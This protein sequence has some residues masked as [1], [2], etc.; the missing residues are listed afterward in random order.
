MNTG[1]H[2]GHAEPATLAVPASTGE[3]Q[4]VI[5]AGVLDEAHVYVREA[6]GDA[7][8]VL[9]VA[10]ETVAALGY[11]SRVE[12]A[13]SRAFAQV[14]TAV[15]PAGESSKS[16]AQAVQ[17]Y[18]ECVRAGLDR[19][20]LVVALGGGVVGDLA[21]FVAATY[22]R[23]VRFVQMPTTL[24][25]H[26]SSIGGKVG[27]NLPEG[28][29]LVGAFHAPRLV[30][31]D[32]LALRTLPPDQ[33]ANGLAEAVKHG[34]IRDPA[35]FEFIEQHAARLLADD[36]EL[37]TDLLLRSCRVKADVVA[38]DEREAGLRA[39]LN[40]GHTV[41]H[42]VEA[43]F[44]GALLHGAAVAV[45]MVVET[46]LARLL[47][48]ADDALEMRLRAALCACG[49]PV[50]WPSAAFSPD[51]EDAIIDRMRLDKKGEKRN[52][53]FVLPHR[54]GAVEIV[55]AVDEHLVRAALRPS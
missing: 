53:T 2:A 20:S 51:V 25:A 48:M 46:R 15:V 19:K 37:M 42:A 24:L 26:D 40:F 33:L 39:I 3:Y 43:Q 27:V 45:G 1:E 49:L 36:P 55:K 18:E 9:I 35:L 22:M 44:L 38:I 41:G 4:V 17:L 31:Y 34:V 28:K 29:N 11:A 23:G 21:G 16:F 13:L 54:L 6:A 12:T 8:A 30:L 52:L 47:G 7:T 5:G 50:E 14:T 32:V 10:D